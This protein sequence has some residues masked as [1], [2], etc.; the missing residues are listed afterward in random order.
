MIPRYSFTHLGEAMTKR[1]PTGPVE[2]NRRVEHYLRQEREDGLHPAVREL[3]Q[4]ATHDEETNRRA[5]EY[6][7]IERGHLA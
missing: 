3:H 4:R 2:G 7:R 5:V 1:S 6:A